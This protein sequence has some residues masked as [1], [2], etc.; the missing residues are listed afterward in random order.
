MEDPVD[1]IG[2]TEPIILS[3][4]PQDHRCVHAHAH[5][6]TQAQATQLAGCVRGWRASGDGEQR[7]LERTFFGPHRD[8]IVKPGQ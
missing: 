5:T 1:G 2:R 4:L 7:F 3:F 8:L 6:R